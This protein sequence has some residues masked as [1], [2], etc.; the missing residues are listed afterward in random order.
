MKILCIYFSSNDERLFNIEG[1]IGN[2][3]F[4]IKIPI[5]SLYYESR[6]NPS[7]PGDVAR[8]ENFDTRGECALSS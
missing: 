7:L 6:D 4:R 2:H 3:L 5:L 1:T 8:N